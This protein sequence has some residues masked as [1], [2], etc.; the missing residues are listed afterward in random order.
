MNDPGLKEKVIFFG[1]L[2]PPYIG[3]AVATL[4]LL[5]SSLKDEF[6]LIHLDLSDHRD[7][8]T[9]GKFDFTNFYLVFKQY[10][11]LIRLIL[12]HK[13]RLVYI[14]VG[15]TT[16]SYCRDSICILIS[17]LFGCKV[18]CHLR[19]GNFKNWYD[20]AG[21]LTK[22]WVRYVHRKVSAQIVLGSNLTHLFNWLIPDERI[23]VVPNGGNYTFPPVTKSEN[24]IR[25]LFLGNFIGSKGVLDVLKAAVIIDQS[26]KIKN[27]NIKFLFAGYWRDTK[28]RM[29]FEKIMKE[30][31]DL[32]VE[33]I[34]PVK[35]DEKLKLLASSDIFVFPTFYPNEGH[36]WVI[37]EAMAAGLPII[38]TDHGAIVESV[39][40]GRNGFIVEPKNPGQIAEKIK[41]LIKKAEIRNKMGRQSLEMYREN[42]TEN[43]M[44]QRMQEIFKKVL[45][46]EGKLK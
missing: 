8:N 31:P 3:P 32:P 28:T 39:I 21:R 33:V 45:G 9:L 24:N 5:N 42:F 4:S 10:F 30:R 17:R 34:G 25:V 43:L 22:W 7:I 16:V 11:N 27:T 18:I 29:E 13:P 1:K 15:Q 36:P 44:V 37:V 19:G 35:G 26:Q 23:F 14:P 46:A 2:P 41:F 20:S 38:S 12:K 6:E 40:D